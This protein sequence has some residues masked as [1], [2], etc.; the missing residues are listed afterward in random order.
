M[1]VLRVDEFGE[2]LGIDQVDCHPAVNDVGP[3]GQQI[4]NLVGDLAEFG[5]IR[6]RNL[7]N[8]R[9]CPEFV[10]PG[11]ELHVPGG[12]PLCIQQAGDARFEVCEG[13]E[14]FASGCLKARTCESFG[15][16]LEHRIR[17]NRYLFM[18]GKAVRP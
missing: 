12:Y 3:D 9:E 6:V 17:A 7:G 16:L 2:G 15:F 14:K 18:R 4:G 8:P 1:P 11:A 5:N 10:Q 13:I